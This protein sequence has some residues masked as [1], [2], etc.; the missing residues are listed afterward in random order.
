VKTAATFAVNGTDVNVAD[1]GV[2]LGG[3]LSGTTTKGFVVGGLGV[4]VPFLKR[5]YLDIGYRYG[6]ILSKTGDVE[7][8][9]SINTQRVIVGVGVTF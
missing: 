8:D 5:L 2:Q 6:R 3:D 7:T 9:T 4:N 1:R